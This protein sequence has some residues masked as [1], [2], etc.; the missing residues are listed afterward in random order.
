LFLFIFHVYF[1]I[2]V[3]VQVDD[4]ELRSIMALFTSCKQELSVKAGSYV[5][6]RGHMSKEQYKELLMQKIRNM[7]FT[8][9]IKKT[10]LNFKK[11]FRN[12]E[13]ETTYGTISYSGD[14]PKEQIHLDSFDEIEEDIFNQSEGER[15]NQ[16][17]R[18]STPTDS[19]D[20]SS[21]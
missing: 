7:N 9:Q 19:L 4:G 3:F 21:L 10:K 17:S 6:G 20:D 8:L 1:L 2:E 13:R 5:R 18:S 11:N 14:R 15:S 16:S 12:T